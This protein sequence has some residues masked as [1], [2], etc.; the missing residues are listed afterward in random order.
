MDMD[1]K[2]AY[3]MA[4]LGAFTLATALACG[5]TTGGGEPC[6]D[7]SQCSAGFV[8]DQG[9]NECIETCS[10]DLECATGEACLPRQ[11]TSSG[12]KTCQID[13]TANNNNMNNPNSC[14]TVDDCPNADDYICNDQMMCEEIGTVVPK[15]FVVLIQ[16]TTQDAAACSNNDPGSDFTFARLIG[17]NGDVLGY[18]Q[19]IFIEITETGKNN[20]QNFASLFD[21]TPPDLDGS[22]QCPNGGFKDGN[23]VSVGCFGYVLTQF[24]STS[25]EPIA[26]DSGMKI[27]VGEYGTQ[28]NG[29]AADSYEI[30]VCSDTAGAK[31]A[32]IASCDRSL[33]SASGFGSFSL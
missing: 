28:C 31:G 32:D 24:V 1:K 8:C 22:E 9:V 20:Y 16:D 15:P 29:S 13:S 18:G 7:D 12:D 26:L 6:D 14:V 3:I 4:Y 11:G 5:S 19:Q 23:V 30:S 2:T 27:E 33:G 25:G 10:S 21:G 17:S